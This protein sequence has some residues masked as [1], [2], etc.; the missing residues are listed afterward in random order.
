MTGGCGERGLQ[1]VARSTP[2]SPQC[3]CH[4]LGLESFV[5]GFVEK[6]HLLTKG[7]KRNQEIVM[8][9]LDSITSGYQSF[10]AATSQRLSLH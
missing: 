7:K 5:L 1:E 8:N 4:L 3:R 10:S 2:P 6:G 9:S